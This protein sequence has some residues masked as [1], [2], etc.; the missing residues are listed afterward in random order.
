MRSI[1][2]SA[3]VVFFVFLSYAHAS[4][5]IISERLANAAKTNLPSDKVEVLFFPV[6]GKADNID[7]SFFTSHNIKYIKAES[8]LQ[9]SVPVNLISELETISGVEFADISDPIVHYKF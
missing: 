2:F 3:L 5:V 4:G 7:T 1:K 8:L 6:D 9:A